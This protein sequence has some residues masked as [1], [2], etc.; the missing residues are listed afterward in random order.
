MMR[1]A[2]ISWAVAIPGLQVYLFRRTYPDLWRNHMEGPT[3]FPALLADW[4]NEKHVKLRLGNA[5]KITFSNGS[6]IH[7]CHCQHEKDR[8]KYQ[9]AEMHVLMIDELT[10]FTE[11]IYVFL[12][13]RV[14]LTGISVPENMND[15]FPRIL[16][17]SNPG[18]VGHG[19][20]KSTFVDFTPHG[21]I[22]RAE[23]ADGGLKRQY[24]PAKLEDNPS[25]AE[26]DPDYRDRLKGLG[27]PAMVKAMEDGDW[28]IIAGG[29]FTDVWSAEKHVLTPFKIPATWT[30]RASFDWGS[31]KP[32]SFGIW[33]ISD[34]TPVAGRV[35]PRGSIIRVREIYFAE[36][37]P[38]GQTS[39]DKGLR[40]T[41]TAMGG[42][43]A[44]ETKN[45]YLAGS[46]ADP[47]I[48]TA[49]GGDSIYR[50]LQAGA[51]QAGGSLQFSPA[52]HARVAGWQ[53]VRG[54][55]A[56][57][58][59]DYPENPGLWVFDVCRN[60]K[61]TVPTLTR[62]PLQPEDIDTSLEDHIADET[63]Y[64]VMSLKK[65]GFKTATITGT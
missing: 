42:R 59:I 32:A 4:I 30:W 3:S 31:T 27:D 60:F 8:F 18:G 13:S 53:A 20:V 14:R 58:R 17:A 63:R 40:L 39:P 51:R 1:V 54:M 62:S 45:I 22:K 57:S 56:E 44:R 12:R 24:I 15:Q 55:L 33:A 36:K 52:N 34:G 43:I 65:A 23:K 47:S 49:H 5:A 41:N 19:W 26:S 48:F 10:H 29:Y 25:L 6:V 2:A 28:D 7:L 21:E 61:R 9:G 64:M 16:A 11:N 50:Q 37:K 35:F 46:V 38:D